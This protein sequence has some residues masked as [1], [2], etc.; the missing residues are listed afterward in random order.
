MAFWIVTKEKF[1]RLNLR[2]E[3]SAP[4]TEDEVKG[5][6]EAV[7]KAPEISD[8]YKHYRGENIPDDETFF[9]NTFVDTYHIPE[10]DYPDFRKICY[11]LWRRLTSFRSTAIK[12]VFSMFPRKSHVQKKNRSELGN[13]GRGCRQ[14]RGNVLCDATICP[15]HGN[16]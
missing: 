1:I 16:Y 4:T 8:V 14:D 9:R 6:R 5:Y 7:L 10:A 12:P 11:N 3:F 13:S 15:T 2:V